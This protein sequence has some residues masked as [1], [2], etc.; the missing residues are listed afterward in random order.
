[1][2]DTLRAVI[3]EGHDAIVLDFFAGS[4]TTLHAVALLNAQDGGSRQCILV[5][6]N[7]VSESEGTRLNKAGYFVGDPEFEAEGIFESVTKP[8]VEAA[9]TGI[10]PD[11]KPVEGEYLDRYLPDHSYADGFEGNVAF[12]RMDYLEPDLVELG[13]Q[14]IAVAPLLWMAAGSVGSWEG[15]D[16]KLPW[17][18]PVDST[19]AVLFDLTESAAFGSMVEGRSEISHAWIVTDSHSAFLEVREELP[20]GVE[21][22]QLYRQYLRNFTVNAPGVLD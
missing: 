5:T 20:A 21:V 18:A 22:G 17:S 9:I 15:W 6:N 10:R 7:D 16:G 4:G 1:M 12:F 8:R 11:G 13:R 3:R 2:A 19:Y 14:Y